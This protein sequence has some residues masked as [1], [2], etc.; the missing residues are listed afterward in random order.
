MVSK[1]FRGRHASCSGRTTAKCLKCP[2]LMGCQSP[3]PFR[4]ADADHV[5][6]ECGLFAVYGHVEA[7][8]FTYLG[9][10]ALQ[11]R[12]QEGAGI[13]AFDEGNLTAHRGVG[14]V[15]EVF[16]PHRLAQ[17]RGAK[18]IGHVR[19]STFG[20]SVLKNVQPLI[21]DYARGSMA[22]AHNGNLVNAHILREELEENGSIFQSTTDS[23]V[24]IQLTARSKKGRFVECV[25]EALKKVVGSY[26]ILA[27]NGEEIIAAR[28]PLGF[29][30]L[31]LG[32]K[33][34]AYIV[35]SETCALDI[36]DAEWLREVNPGEVVVISDC[37]L[38]SIYPFEPVAPKHCIFEFVYLA[39]PDS[40]IFGRSVDAV[41]K[42]LGANVAKLA[43]V[44][45]DLVM[46]VP[47]S[48]NPAALGYA[49]ESGIPFDMG[50]IRNHYVGRT[51]IEP[52]QRI[53]DF[54]VK[55]K[56]NPT[57]S[58]IEGKRIVLIDDSIVRGTTS[59]KILKMLRRN[60]AKEIHFRVSSPPIIGSC[61]Y[62]IDT[63]NKDKLIASNMT[64]EEIRRYLDVDSLVYQSIEGLVSATGCATDAFCLGCFNDRY[65]TPVP[66]DYVAARVSRRHVDTS[67][68]PY[69]SQKTMAAAEL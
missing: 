55:I 12:G 23:E 67:T 40:C 43:P 45:A 27:T 48:S 26:C 34:D 37:G 29:R 47:D 4:L 68:E 69:G 16:K 52:D 50:F 58:V 56:L 54:G 28:D 63:P 8:T 62:G 36:I 15:S 46:A 39:R 13:V 38:E 10:Y 11:H 64:V 22:F 66:S 17:V 1:Q 31:W 65:P 30:P 24:I 9:L 59:K 33:D 19:Y 60:G 61:F 41:R 5:R 42:Q 21:V 53:R 3:H 7:P 25:I 2:G 18:A 49:H 32:I 57:R 20:T 14:L 51:F 6:E 44:E 35:A